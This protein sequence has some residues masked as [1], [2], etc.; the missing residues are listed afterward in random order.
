[1]AVSPVHTW[2][3]Y[4]KPSGHHTFSKKDVIQLKSSELVS[5]SYWRAAD[6]PC[7]E[8]LKKWDGLV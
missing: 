3:E 8:G 7:R 1:M 5:G 2:L 4:L 6:M